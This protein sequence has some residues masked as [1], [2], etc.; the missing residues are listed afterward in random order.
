M[1]EY[2]FGRDTNCDFVILDPQR[3]VSRKHGCVYEMNGEYYIKDI[4]SANGIY[5]NNKRIPQN[6]ATK[7]KLS[8][9]ITLSKDYVLDVFEV[10][11]INLDKTLVMS[12][13]PKTNFSPPNNNVLTLQSGDKKIN[14]DIEKTSISDIAEL[15]STPYITIGRGGDNKLVLAHTF[16][17]RNHCKL[18]MITPQIIEVIDLGSSN[19]T[20]VDKQKLQPNKPYQFS[21]AAIIKLGSSLTIDLKKIFPGIQ[22]VQRNKPQVS[23]PQ[24]APQRNIEHK[25]ITKAERKAFEELEGLWKEYLDRQSNAN[26]ATMTYGIGGAALGLAAAALTGLSGGI[27]GII[28]M[29]GSGLVGRYLGQQ[30]TNEI[31]GD[32]TYEDM[33]LETYC[34]PRCKE[35]FQKKPWITIR[36][37]FKCKL[38]FK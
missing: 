28:L 29:S 12:S 9:V 21:S 37:C 4:G 17:S 34:C 18:R 20:Y 13:G 36:E 30:K 10:M 32:L 38:K 19:G 22:I 35:S 8:D 24:G 14:L 27:G 16:I 33:F 7:F 5:I 15:D 1:K 6:R 25:P 23:S 26:K 11:P 31:R 2:F 3:R